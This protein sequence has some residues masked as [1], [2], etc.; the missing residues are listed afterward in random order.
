MCRSLQGDVEWRIRS[1]QGS[2]DF[3][4]GE[5]DKTQEGEYGKHNSWAP[6]DLMAYSA[7]AKR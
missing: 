3:E 6:V 4:I 7:F 2:E 5:P 1:S